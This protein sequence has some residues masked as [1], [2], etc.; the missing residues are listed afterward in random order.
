MKKHI[1]G[2]FRSLYETRMHNI[3]YTVESNQKRRHCRFFE[4]SPL[5]EPLVERARFVAT[6]GV[7]SCRA[8][9]RLGRLGSGDAGTNVDAAASCSSAGPDCPNGCCKSGV[10]ADAAGTTPAAACAAFT[11]ACAASTAASAATAGSASS[12]VH[13]SCSSCSCCSRCSRCSRTMQA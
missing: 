4:G 11:P 2:I 3:Q 12:G 9:L 8:R 10:G 6:P 5:S 7:L 13:A 1:E